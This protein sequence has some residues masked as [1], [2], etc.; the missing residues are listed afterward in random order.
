MNGTIDRG[1]QKPKL[2][3]GSKIDRG[4]QK[5][6]VKKPPYKGG[7]FDRTPVLNHPPLAREEESENAT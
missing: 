6:G 1:G 5:R 2:T 4:G 3:L 7:L